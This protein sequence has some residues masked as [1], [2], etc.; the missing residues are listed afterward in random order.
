MWQKERHFSTWNLGFESEYFLMRIW[1]RAYFELQ[2]ESDLDLV[3]EIWNSNDLSKLLFKKT[4]F[5]IRI[6]GSSGS[7]FGIRI[8][9]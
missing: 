8:R 5:R 7:V 9:S 6:Q 2:L 3:V 1:I 4:E